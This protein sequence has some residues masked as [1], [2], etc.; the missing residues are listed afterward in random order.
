MILEEAKHPESKE[1]SQ[2]MVD[3]LHKK[4]CTLGTKDSGLS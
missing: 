4:H 1:P 3:L 2:N